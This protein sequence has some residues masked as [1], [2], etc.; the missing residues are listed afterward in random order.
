M[1]KLALIGMVVAGLLLSTSTALAKPTGM[2][3]AEFQALITPSEGSNVNQQLEEIGA[4]AVP[5]KQPV[6]PVDVNQQLEEIGAWAVPTEPTVTPVDVNQ[7]LEEIGA[8][9]V[10]TKQTVSTPL[11]SEKLA[12]V[13]IPAPE[14]TVSST[15]QGF[16]WNDAGIG[17]ALALG[18]TL[19]IGAVLTVRHH[20]HGPIAH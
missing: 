8:W 18:G 7:Q 12:G 9:A 4:W 17:A 19:G 13:G 3:K 5:T 6:T 14:T 1:K 20:Q 16:D 2:T 10:P 15:A 11:V